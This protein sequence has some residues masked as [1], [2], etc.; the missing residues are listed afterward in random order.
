[1]HFGVSLRVSNFVF[2]SYHV[3]P[4]LSCCL[5]KLARISVS[6]PSR[7]NLHPQC[8]APAHAT[9]GAGYIVPLETSYIIFGR[10]GI[11]SSNSPS[12]VFVVCCA[13]AVRVL[14]YHVCCVSPRN[15]S[16]NIRLSRLVARLE[17]GEGAQ[18]SIV[19]SPRHEASRPFNYWPRP[20]EH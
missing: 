8:H 16:T 3:Y 7:V 2:I 11:S 13:C 5:R 10:R 6:S 17:C 12:R 9:C 19:C 14:V 15:Q 18:I 1:M 4:T 20:R